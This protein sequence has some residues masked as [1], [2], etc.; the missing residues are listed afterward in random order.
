MVLF[1]RDRLFS[2]NRFFLTNGGDRQPSNS[3]LYRFC[4]EKSSTSSQKAQERGQLSDLLSKNS[5]L[6]S[7]VKKQFCFPQFQ[8]FQDSLIVMLT[9]ISR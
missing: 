1:G 7:K 3:S 6:L 5:A 4:A 2:S 9:K 8:N